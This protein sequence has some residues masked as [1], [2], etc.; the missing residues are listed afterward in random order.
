MVSRYTGGI[1]MT[2]VF[3]LFFTFII[4]S[5]LF[6][7]FTRVKT[8]YYRV[9]QARMVHV[10]EMVLT[11]QAT[12]NDWQMTFGM[13]VR[14]SPEL[15]VIRLQCVDIEEECYIGNQRPPYLFSSDGLEQLQHILGDLKSIQTSI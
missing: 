3:T 7:A 11:G 14:H 10:L 1:M 5:V 2:I 9:D 15:E 6:Y 13:V 8:P 4:V 12:D